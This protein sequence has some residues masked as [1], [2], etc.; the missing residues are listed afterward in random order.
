[1]PRGGATFVFELRFERP[2][3]RPRKRPNLNAPGGQLGRGRE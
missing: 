1:M 2:T 3:A